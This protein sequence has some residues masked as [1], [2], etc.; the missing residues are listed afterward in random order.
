MVFELLHNWNCR[1]T[2]YLAVDRK[3]LVKSPDSHS[4]HFYWELKI[5]KIG[6]FIGQQPTYT[7]LTH[8]EH[9]AGPYTALAASMSSSDSAAS[10]AS[11]FYLFRAVKIFTS[12]FEE[13]VYFLWKFSCFSSRKLQ[14]I[15][16]TM[17][18]SRRMIIIPPA[19]KAHVYDCI[20]ELDNWLKKLKHKIF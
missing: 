3:W 6:Q 17:H 1:P 18:I 5:E 14:H 13:S 12:F 11:P 8:Y 15:F 10:C 16:F 4:S 7:S 19:I 9:K 20:F 2:C